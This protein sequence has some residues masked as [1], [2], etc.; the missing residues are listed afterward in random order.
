MNPAM[1]V[2]GLALAAVGSGER[3]PASVRPPILEV[4]PAE[5]RA[6]VVVRDWPAAREKL[7]SLHVAAFAAVNPPF[8]AVLRGLAIVD[9]LDEHGAIAA[10]LMPAGDEDEMAAADGLLLVL[11][12]VDV[13]HLMTLWE[14]EPL[15]DGAYRIRLMGRE[16]FLAGVNGYAII[17]PSL[18]VVRAAAHP[19]RSLAL[20]LPSNLKDLLGRYDVGVWIDAQA[21]TLDGL[22]AAPEESAAWWVRA[23]AWLFGEHRQI[24]AGVR[25]LPDSI[26]VETYLEPTDPIH[27]ALTDTNA[28]LLIGLPEGDHAW[29]FSMVNDDRGSSMAMLHGALIAALV[30][31][32][33]LDSSRASELAS[34]LA[35]IGRRT[36]RVLWF[37]GAPD[38]PA[39]EAAGVWRARGTAGMLLGEIRSLVRFMQ[40]GSA[41]DER[42]NRLLASLVYRRAVETIDGVVVDQVAV[43]FTDGEPTEFGSVKR[44]LGP[45]GLLVRVGVVDDRHVVV[46][47]GGGA[48]RF[49]AIVAAVRR[50]ADPVRARAAMDAVAIHLPAGRTLAAYL[51]PARMVTLLEAWGCAWRTQDAVYEFAASP[52]PVGATLST[53]GAG[54]L[55]RVVVP[56]DVL[57][58]LKRREPGQPGAADGKNSRS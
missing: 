35:S 12:T 46:S 29:A 27:A 30:Q 7:A 38:P 23:G 31:G 6:V 51:F 55:W 8:S 9:G 53:E 56:A 34:Q 40:S 28:P 52:V 16:S 4:I 39:F 44:L 54:L 13:A 15:E 24:M 45:E 22:L 25:F 18:E 20:R 47:L 5:A 26:S 41:A 43:D 37:A 11:P 58:S 57:Q 1:F 14:P 19:P 21:G 2:L 3:A 49:Q 50:G 17:G 33:W 42:I 36:Q 32:G 10:V 48:R